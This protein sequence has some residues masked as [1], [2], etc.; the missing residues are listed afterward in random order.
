MRHVDV[1]SPL[2]LVGDEAAERGQPGLG[3]RGFEFT[4]F[5]FRHLYAGA[6]RGSHD[7]VNLVRAAGGLL[8][9]G[10]EGYPC[11]RS[12]CAA[13]ET[14]P[15]KK[16]EQDCY[17]QNESEQNR[18]RDNPRDLGRD[19]LW[20][21]ALGKPHQASSTIGVKTYPPK[22]TVFIKVGSRGFGSI[23]PAHAADMDIDAALDRTDGT[24]VNYLEQL[25]ARENSARIAAE[26]EEQIEFHAGQ[27]HPDRI[28][29]VELPR[30]GIDSPTSEPQRPR[31]KSIHVVRALRAAQKDADAGHQLAGIEGLRDV[32]IGT[33]LQTDDSIN[34]LGARR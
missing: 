19:A 8:Q 34:G 14:A 16:H 2:E 17:G 6:T 30:C 26:G 25:L 23:F 18:D 5:D 33:E 15:L 21:Q 11:C 31:A 4:Q 22:R 7:H 29:I 12:V 1:P 20:D 28:W 9:L 13:L 10:N 24:A 3:R 27:R 32:V